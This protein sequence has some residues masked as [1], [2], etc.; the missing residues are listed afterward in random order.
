MLTSYTLKING[1]FV[2]NWIDFQLACECISTS[3]QA[4][5][6]SNAQCVLQFEQI[7]EGQRELLAEFAL[8]HGMWDTRFICI[9]YSGHE[10]RII[11]Q[12]VAAGDKHGPGF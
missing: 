1:Q 7:S 9:E 12:P 3:C 4:L 6:Q 10:Y 11:P 5:A 8:A 2:S